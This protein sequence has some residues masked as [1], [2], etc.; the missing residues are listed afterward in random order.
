MH[1]LHSGMTERA[2]SESV[3]RAKTSVHREIAAA[4]VADAWSDIGPDPSSYFSQLVEIHAAPRWLWSAPTLNSNSPRL[5]AVCTRCT[6]GW[7]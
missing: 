5:S 1:A 2:Y 7:M 6:Q 4:T 3:G